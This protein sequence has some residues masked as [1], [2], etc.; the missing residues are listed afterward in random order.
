MNTFDLALSH[1]IPPTTNVY[2]LVTHRFCIGFGEGSIPPE[3]SDTNCGLFE[4]NIS[5]D[6]ALQKSNTNLWNE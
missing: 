5:D 2:R 1:Y 6:Y 4:E 3:D